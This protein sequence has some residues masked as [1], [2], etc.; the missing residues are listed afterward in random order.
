VNGEAFGLPLNQPVEHSGACPDCD[1]TTEM[2][3]VTPRVFVLTV[4]HDPTCPTL[5][6]MEATA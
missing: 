2:V 5:H 4:S 6:R 3:E 1:A